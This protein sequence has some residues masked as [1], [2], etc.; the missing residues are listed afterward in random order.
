MNALLKW[1]RKATDFVASPRSVPGVSLEGEVLEQQ[2]GWL[3]RYA[4]PLA[5]W[6]KMLEATATSLKYIREHGYHRDAQQE[7]QVKLVPFTTDQ[8]SPA[9]RVAT[10]LLTFV[11]EQSSDLSGNQ[12]LLGS[13]EVLES[14]IGKAKQLEGQHSRSGFTKMILGTAASVAKLSGRTLQAALAAVKVRDV[15]QW[16]QKHI[17]TS[18]QGQRMHAFATIATE[19]NRDKL[20]LTTP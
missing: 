6:S 1:S 10:G 11:G 5:A 4:E 17:G 2:M 16:V 3:R 9:S 8:P 12:R 20:Q 15:T 19:Q 18:V 14:L 13:S 7:L